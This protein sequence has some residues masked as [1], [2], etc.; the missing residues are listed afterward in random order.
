[1]NRMSRV[2]APPGAKKKGT[3]LPLLIVL[4]IFLEKGGGDDK[5]EKIRGAGFEPATFC[6]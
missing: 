1:M 3:F 6:V 5:G 2:R 4:A